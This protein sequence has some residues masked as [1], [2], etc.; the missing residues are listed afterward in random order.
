MAAKDVKFGAD[1]RE[2]LLRGV[3]I[4]A[5]AVEI[6]LSTGPQCGDR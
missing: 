2:R 1:A 4:L 3:D 6:T 5:N